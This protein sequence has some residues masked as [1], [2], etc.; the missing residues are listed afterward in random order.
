MFMSEM[1]KQSIA[2]EWWHAHCYG[3]VTHLVERMLD[4]SERDQFLDDLKPTPNWGELA[5]GEGWELA[6]DVEELPEEFEDDEYVNLDSGESYVSQYPLDSD[7]AWEDLCNVHSIEPETFEPAMF[8]AISEHAGRAL[9]ERGEAVASLD[10]L[11]VWARQG[12]GQA[13]Y[14]DECVSNAALA[15]HREARR[16]E[17]VAA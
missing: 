13:C 15:D 1:E 14:I 9:K 8:F 4:E 5:R 7:G 16:R 11:T 6:E 12:G 17:E 2:R 10:G 3:A